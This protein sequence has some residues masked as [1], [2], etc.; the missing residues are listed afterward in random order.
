MVHFVT[1][2]NGSY[3]IELFTSQTRIAPIKVQTIPRQELMP[4]RILARLVNTVKEALEHCVQLM[5]VYY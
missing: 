1:E 3:H 4:A 2:L 5:G